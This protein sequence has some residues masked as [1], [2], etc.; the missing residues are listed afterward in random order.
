MQMNPTGLTPVFSAAPTPGGDRD[1]EETGRCHA[2]RSPILTMRRGADFGSNRGC[3]QRCA[4]RQP[5]PAR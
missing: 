4:T 2:C 5:R 3:P 1:W